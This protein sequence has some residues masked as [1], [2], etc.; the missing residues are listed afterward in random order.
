VTIVE[1]VPELDADVIEHPL[2]KDHRVREKIAVRRDGTG[3][4]ASSHYTVLETFDG[5]AFLR[6]QPKT[7]RTHQIRGPLA[8][9]AH[10]GGADRQYGSRD[11]LTL[12]DLARGRTEADEVLIARQA[13]HAASLRILHPMT[14]EPLFFESPLPADMEHTLAA[15]R[16]WRP[17][18]PR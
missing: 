14:R 8:A 10:R 1:G 18:A 4:E 5:F 16:Q 7:G 6:V 12:Q 9:S 3:K 2:G 11:R 17:A 13:L 15:L